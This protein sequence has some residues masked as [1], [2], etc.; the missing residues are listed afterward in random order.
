MMMCVRTGWGRV[1]MRVGE[2]QADGTVLRGMVRAIHDV[3]KMTQGAAVPMEGVDVL[4]ARPAIGMTHAGAAAV[5]AR[6]IAPVTARCV[7][8]AHLRATTGTL[9]ARVDVV[10]VAV[11]LGI[12][13]PHGAH[14]RVEDSG[15]MRTLA[16]GVVRGWAARREPVTHAI[17]VARVADEARQSQRKGNSPSPKARELLPA[18]LCWA[19]RWRLCFSW[20][21]GQHPK[22]ITLPPCQ[23]AQ[24]RLCHRRLYRML[25]HRRQAFSLV[26]APRMCL[27][28][29][30]RAAASKR[31]DSHWAYTGAYPG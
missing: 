26:L 23:P 4:A 15:A 28:S 25:P 11:V 20:S 2:V 19:S 10:A 24:P 13:A 16:H 30:A 5:V 18:R 6:L 22:S 14:H 29:R 1:M 12:L 17:P 31:V 8:D 9:L 3:M 27:W 7:A 21:R